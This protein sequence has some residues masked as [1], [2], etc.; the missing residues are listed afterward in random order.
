[1]LD[2]GNFYK[3]YLLKEFKS[4][5]ANKVYV[6]YNSVSFVRA[7]IERIERLDTLSS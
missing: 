7:S 1:M 5:Q 6:L 4:L 2:S 3:N